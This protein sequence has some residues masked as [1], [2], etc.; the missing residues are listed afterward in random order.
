MGIGFDA[1]DAG[2]GV[3][4][5][6]LEVDGAEVTREV[7]DE[8]G[9]RCGDVEPETADPYEF[10]APLPCPLMVAGSV[11]FDSAALTDGTHTIALRV[12]DAAGNQSAVVQRT[13]TS[14]NA[15]ISISAPW[16]G[17][18]PRIGGL[19]STDAGGWDGAPDAFEYRWLRCDA[20]GANCAAIVG[21][22][23][24]Q[25]S[26]IAADAYH[27]LVAEVV[28]GNSSGSAVARSAPSDLV[29]D[30]EGRTAPGG[31]PRPGDPTDN[32]DRGGTGDGGAAPGGSGG[33]GAGASGGGSGSAGGGAGGVAGIPTLQNPLGDQA[34]RAPN[35]RGASARARVTLAL[36][37]AGGGSATRVRSA[38]NRRWT[39][40]G[41][42]TDGTGRAIEGARLNLLH[43]VAGRRWVARGLVRTGP[44]GR[45]TQTLPGGPSRTVR[46]TYFPFGDSDAFRASNTVSID[47]LAP[48]T[49]KTDRR[50]LGA[51]RT[52][53]ISGRA[54]GG[55]IPAG[56]LLVT[57]QGYQQGWGWRTFRTIR[58]NRGGAW[59][60]SYRFRAIS[61]RFAFRALVPQQG[62]YPFVTT[63][64]RSVPV[65]LA[66]E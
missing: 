10:A 26:P 64:S 15:P 5:S 19:V 1:A 27:R 31:S 47:V 56:G 46:V 9:G 62:R 3:Y 63:T 35:G 34:G 65:M 36:R 7:V 25:H 2:G 57:L 20:A 17:G 40:V 16:L 29:A 30:A 6:I 54:G 38:I 60:T 48:L 12:E 55:S 32:G 50:I 37:R 66:A 49:I 8:N 33:P 53:T 44:G 58:T 4:R 45:F 23:G 42:L 43:R 14:H 13:V 59:R 52:V 41:R 22:S 39:V 18:D 28:A 21:A 61:G 11:E 24:P 51:R